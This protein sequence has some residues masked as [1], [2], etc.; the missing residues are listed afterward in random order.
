LLQPFGDTALSIKVF[1]PI[2]LV[3]ATHLQVVTEATPDV[4]PQRLGLL[5]KLEDAHASIDLALFA[6]SEPINVDPCSIGTVKSGG[7]GCQIVRVTSPGRAYSV[8][9]E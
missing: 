2:F 8:G 7:Y 5:C 4:V 1:T 6:D 9:R 3:I